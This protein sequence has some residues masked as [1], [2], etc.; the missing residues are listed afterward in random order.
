ML[1]SL[2][3]ILLFFFIITKNI[4]ANEI[5]SLSELK[6]NNSSDNYSQILMER[7]AAIYAALS[8]LEN[9][10]EYEN[11]YKIFLQSSILE[12]LNKNNNLKEEIVYKKSIDDFKI[13]LSFILQILEQNY[14]I[15]NSFLK[16][17]WIEQDFNTCKKL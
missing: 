10:N 1:K 11:R 17:H 7:C 12:I 6:E 13:S 5:K 8:I 3:F 4:N 16:N 9:N 2:F 15:N 14:K